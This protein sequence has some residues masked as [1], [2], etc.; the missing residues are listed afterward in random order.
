M[1]VHF[2]PETE[3]RLAELSGKTGRRTDELIEDAVAGYLAE[4]AEVRASLDRRY[5][6]AKSGSVKL[7]DGE[8]AMTQL[9]QRS[10][11][12]RRIRG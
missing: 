4:I 2:T 1:E 11:E 10:K 7:I 6:E 12:R 5:E 8:E 9:Q 3:S